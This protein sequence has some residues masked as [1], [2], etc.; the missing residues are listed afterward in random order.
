MSIYPLLRALGVQR[1]KTMRDHQSVNLLKRCL[2]GSSAAST[3]CSHLLTFVDLIPVRGRSPWL[4]SSMFLGSVRALGRPG[5]VSDRSAL[6]PSTAVWTFLEVSSLPPSS[7]LHALQRSFLLF[8]SHGHTTK[9]VS[10]W[11]MWWLA[12]PLHRSWT[13]HFWFGL[14]LFCSE[15]ILAFSSLLCAPFA[16][17]LSV[18]PNIHCHIS[19]SVWWQFCTVCSSA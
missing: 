1:I 19:K 11:H 9:G 2:A 7:L 4:L 18:A 12:W 17:L 15:S 5:V 16:A 3:F 14:S 6:G 13:F 10:G 8:S